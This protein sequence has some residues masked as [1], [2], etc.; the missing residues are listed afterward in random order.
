M[1]KVA[2]TRHDQYLSSSNRNTARPLKPSLTQNRP[3]QL[4]LNREI[5][6]ENYPN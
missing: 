5:T 6:H 1:A 4:K 3:I 2:I